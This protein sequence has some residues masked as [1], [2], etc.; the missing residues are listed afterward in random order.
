MARK[1]GKKS[2]LGGAI[3][4]GIRCSLDILLVPCAPRGERETISVYNYN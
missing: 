3:Q 1:V 2:S 4:G